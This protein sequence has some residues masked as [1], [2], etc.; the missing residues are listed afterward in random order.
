MEKVAPSRDVCGRKYLKEADLPEEQQAFLTW[1]GGS[2]TCWVGG[3]FYHDYEVWYDG[4]I[5][6]R[7]P[8]NDD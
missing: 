1:N 7:V 5:N 2:T 4:W 6:G 8:V 3:S